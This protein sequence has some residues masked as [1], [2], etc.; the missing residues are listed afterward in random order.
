M[1]FDNLIKF[2]F[3]DRKPTP[4]QCINNLTPHVMSVM[5][6][7]VGFRTRANLAVSPLP[8]SPLPVPFSY[9]KFTFPP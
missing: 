8:Q 3:S 1:M 9:L 2:S 6:P 4:N 7:I 5:F